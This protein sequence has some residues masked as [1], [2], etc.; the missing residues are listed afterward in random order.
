M[1]AALS[2]QSAHTTQAPHC[3]C[4]CARVRV[5]VCAAGTYEA[6]GLTVGRFALAD[7]RVQQFGRA[8]RVK[9]G[10]TPKRRCEENRA[11]REASFPTSLLELGL[12]ARLEVA[13][14]RADAARDAYDKVR[15][16]GMS[17]EEFEEHQMAM[18]P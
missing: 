11:I 14:R 9:E 5:C 16:N 18:L 1:H 10:A 12:K 3:V 2:A 4:V 7:M 15:V 8:S 6:I 13:R 17:P